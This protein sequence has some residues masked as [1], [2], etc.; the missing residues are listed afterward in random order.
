MP[1]VK[2]LCTISGWLFAFHIQDANATSVRGL[3]PGRVP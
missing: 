1:L 3:K 2:R